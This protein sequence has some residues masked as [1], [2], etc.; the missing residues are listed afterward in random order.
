MHHK[1]DSYSDNWICF[2]YPRVGKVLVLHSIDTTLRGMQ[3][4]LAS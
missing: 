4:F 3:N 1:F 2:I